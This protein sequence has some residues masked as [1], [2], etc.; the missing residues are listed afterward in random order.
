MRASIIIPCRNNAALFAQTLPALCRQ[1]IRRDEYEIIVVDDA[2][3]TPL[4]DEESLAACAAH[5]DLHFVRCASHGGA[6]AARNRGVRAARGDV[7]VFV[8]DDAFVGPRFLAR[9]LDRHR[10][11]A[12]VAG[13]IVQVRQIPSHIDERLGFRGFH[14]HPLPGGNSSAPARVVRE[15]GAFDEDF[16]AYGWADQE[17]AE[18]LLQLGLRRAYAWGAPIYHYK[19]PGYDLDLV[20][21]IARE[22]ERGRMGARFYRK[23]PEW[24]IGVTTKTAPAIRRVI[25]SLARAAGVPN[26]CDRVERGVIDGASIPAWRAALLRA[27]VESRSG[28]AE[29]AR[30]DAVRQAAPPR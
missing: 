15:V 13:P 14:R 27:W 16:H 22:R 23:H 4:S 20:A 7:L 12:I 10:T 19:P 6:A 1:T 29:L 17:L 25:A 9:H 8:D 3:N 28:A 11:P 24:A 21:Q 2:S 26:L 18:R 30:L 5:A